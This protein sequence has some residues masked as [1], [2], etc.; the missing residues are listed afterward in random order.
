LDEDGFL[1][2]LG[3]AFDAREIDGTLVTP[4]EMEEALCQ[5]LSI[6]H[7]VVIRDAVE[8]VTIAAVTAWPGL[9][10]VDR[11]CRQAITD[12][13]GAA[14]VASLLVVPVDRMPLTEQGKPDR[15]AIKQLARRL[16]A[17]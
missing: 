14:A 1:H 3:R 8:Q 9:S 5:H 6:R 4:T 15:A 2:I 11:V 10:V 17:A 7:A 16:L 12:R 13:F